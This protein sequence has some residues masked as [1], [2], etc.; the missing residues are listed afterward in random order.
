MSNQ[1]NLLDLINV[2]SLP[3]SASGPTHSDK[4]DGQ[5]TDLSGQVHAHANLSARQAKE[6]GLLTSGTYGR[7]STGLLASVDLMLSLASK[8]QAKTVS[9]GLTLYKL[10]WKDRVTPAGQ[11]IPALRAS[12][13]RTLGKECIGWPTQTARDYKDISKCQNV[14]MNSLLGRVVWMAGWP[15]PQCADDNMSRTKNPQEFSAMR[16][17]TRSMGQNLADTTQGGIDLIHP[18]TISISGEIRSGLNSQITNGGALNPAH[19]RWLMGLP[20]EWDDC[21]VTAMQSLPRK[22]R[23]SSKQ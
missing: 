12:A 20:P 1:M 7:S 4:Q 23:R 5:M 19:P 22:R 15:T 13:H 10:T 6:M 9:D 14:P 21:A 3:V 16:L 18:M 8:L 11:S 17:S 2:T